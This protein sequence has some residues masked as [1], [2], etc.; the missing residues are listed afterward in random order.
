[1]EDYG[2]AR[3]YLNTDT[4]RWSYGAMKGRPGDEWLR[5]LSLRVIDEQLDLAAR[6]GFGAVHVDRRAYVDRGAAIESELRRRLGAPIA[7]GADGLDVA[8]RMQPMGVAPLPREALLPGPGTPIRFDREVLS[9]SV[10]KISGFSGW[11]PAGR[12]TEGPMARIELAEPLSGRVTLRLE[13][14]MAMP[15]S[16]D[17]DVPIRIGGVEHQ[18]RLGSGPTTADIRFDLPGPANAIEIVIPNPVAPR[19]LNLNSDPR[20]LGIMVKS[21]TISPDPHK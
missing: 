19:D 14:A 2:L 18:F 21:I 4:L 13:T 11:E 5:L 7:Q 3:G 1:M 20:K 6:S 9:A 17:V 8:Y 10:S 15:P 12:W 16:T